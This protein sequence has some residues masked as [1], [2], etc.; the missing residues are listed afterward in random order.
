[1]GKQVIG[2]KMF[3]IKY[4][5]LLVSFMAI[6]FFI[7][8]T[9]SL[10]K[11]ESVLIHRFEGE[12]PHDTHDVKVF[13]NNRN[14]QELIIM[15]NERNFYLYRF[16]KGTW[17]R[18]NEVFEIADGLP[19]L[20]GVIKSW[21]VY[22]INHDQ[23]DEIV[24]SWGTII[25][26]AELKKDKFVTRYYKSEYQVEQFAVGDLD[27]DG[28]DEWAIFKSEYVID[29]PYVF[30]YNSICLA[31]LG[32]DRLEYFWHDPENK[33]YSSGTYIPPAKITGIYDINNN[34][35]NQIIVAEA[36]SDVSPQRYIAYQWS[37]NGVEVDT[38]FYLDWE[39][40]LPKQE[41]KGSLFYGL[42]SV[43]K[44]KHEN[45]LLAPG[46]IAEEGYGESYEFLF[47]LKAGI[48]QSVDKLFKHQGR[49]LPNKVLWLNTNDHG[50]GFIGLAYTKEG[51]YEYHYYELFS[52]NQ[53]R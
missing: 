29:H 35:I 46:M 53:G 5:N 22:D 19:A 25:A 37:N 44:Y 51:K 6:L 39:G 43:L 10:G 14:N 34:G 42:F 26:I 31:R 24:V 3:S 48:I 15:R 41:P 9:P 30:R 12:L 16:V 38:I 1:M 4:Y 28:I 8:L 20:E 33:H 36:K 47:K 45:Y 21:G 50:S 11:A 23:I 52:P 49:R 27:Q 7:L 13:R 2:V 40:K 32:L 18:V 17:V